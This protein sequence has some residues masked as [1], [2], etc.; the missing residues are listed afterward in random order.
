MAFN[1]F[2]SSKWSILT[3]LL[4]SQCQFIRPQK[5]AV[6]KQVSLNYPY[7]FQQLKTDSLFNS[8]QVISIL[9][10]AKKDT[11]VYYF[12]LAH[13]PS[14]LRKTSQFGLNETAIIA[15]N[16]GFFD[17]DNG[18]S[19]TYLE[20][21][22]SVFHR[23]KVHGE[24]WAIANWAKTGAIIL[25]KNG[26]LNLEAAKAQKFYAQSTAEESV[27]V[28][29]PLLIESGKVLKLVDTKFVTKRHPRTCL[30]ETTNSFLL[31]TIDG[32]KHFAKGMSLLE[33]Q[34][35]L[36]EQKCINAI[37]LDGGGSTT[38]WIKGQGIV[39]TP[40]DP[41]GERKVANALLVKLRTK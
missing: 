7:Q 19:A 23:H 31:L 25:N 41:L 13:H 24:K 17:M 14:Q 26:G 2:S 27:L 29:G 21:Q 38:M 34:T 12:D 9:R 4:F 16:G 33:L 22:D 10:L 37:N 6:A 35:F 40:S 36:M 8:S 1:F 20:A 15:I 18:G 28:T 11:A 30:C 5:V 3:L 39:N 32:R